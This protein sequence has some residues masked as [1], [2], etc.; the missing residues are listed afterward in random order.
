MS[1]RLKTRRLPDPRSEPSVLCAVIGGWA[2]VKLANLATC[3]FIISSSVF[4]A[5]AYAQP[6]GRTANAESPSSPQSAKHCYPDFDPITLSPY[7]ACPRGRLTEHDRELI[8]ITAD[9]YKRITNLARR[10]GKLSEDQFRERMD[11]VR[12][13]RSDARRGF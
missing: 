6:V 12:E 11:R 5:M 1:Q 7:P 8:D 4:W 3:A 13:A 10:E 2:T 9:A